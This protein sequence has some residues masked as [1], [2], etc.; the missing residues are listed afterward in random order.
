MKRKTKDY[1]QRESRLAAYTL[2]GF[3]ALGLLAMCNW[4]GKQ[5]QEPVLIITASE[6]RQINAQLERLAKLEAQER[7]LLPRQFKG[8][9]DRFDDIFTAYAS[10]PEAFK[11][12]GAKR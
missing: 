11:P 6:A 4:E 5:P 3:T 1:R 2:A 8:G 12:E 10:N 9:G 7:M